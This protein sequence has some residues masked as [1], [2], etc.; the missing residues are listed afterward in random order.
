MLKTTTG[1][2]E[3]F[4]KEFILRKLYQIRKLEVKAKRHNR[5]VR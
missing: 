5:S 4:S 3:L 1:A 2:G